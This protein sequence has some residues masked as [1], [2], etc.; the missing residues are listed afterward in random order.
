MPENAPSV[1]LSVVIA[2]YNRAPQLRQL[3]DE[4]LQQDARGVNFEVL[5][6]DNNS[7]DDTAAVVEAA[8]LSDRSGLI[9]YFF[10]PRQGVSYARN[11]GI[12][13]AR[14]PIIAIID[15][16]V[17]PARD[18]AYS[19]K[20]SMDRYPEADCIG[21]RVQ[22]V[23]KRPR[24][25]WLDAA[26]SGPVA[27]QDWPEPRW[28][29]RE[30]ASNCLI[31]ANLAFRREL[32]DEVGLFSPDFPRNQD[33]ELEMR[34][35]RAGKQGLYLPAMNVFVDIPEERLTKR[36]HRQWR[37]TTGSYHAK[38]RFLDLVDG[39]G[40]FHD[41]EPKGRRLFGTPLF[42]YRQCLGHLIGWCKT[43]VSNDADRR[44]YHESR[45]WY[46]ASFFWTRFKTDVLSRFRLAST[47]G[48]G[49]QGPDRVNGEA[50]GTIAEIVETPSVPDLP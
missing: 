26:H 39:H 31:T 1:D 9:R 24:P 13:Q 6:V 45:L 4:L 15:D 29:N 35:W 23:W 34:F 7:R 36:Y 8:R 11:T 42:M 30:S 12:A 21:G 19:V 50:R 18:W 38:L 16:D 27:L 49:R 25:S 40:R 20:Q 46:C 43:L 10:E 48:S 47:G 32:F 17:V 3:L 44:F 22:A 33:R 14:A 37:V 5:V 41:H 2:T 28:V